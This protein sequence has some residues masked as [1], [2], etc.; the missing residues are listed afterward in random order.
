MR[1]AKGPTKGHYFLRTVGAGAEPTFSVVSPTKIVTDPN[2]GP[3]AMRAKGAGKRLVERLVGDARAGG[4]ALV[5]PCP[6]VDAQ[7]QR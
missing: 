5:A 1:P 3:D 2:A 4:F 6:F 7:A